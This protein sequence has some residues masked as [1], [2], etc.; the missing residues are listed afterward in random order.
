MAEEPEK[1]QPMLF[2]ESV[3]GEDDQSTI[4]TIAMVNHMSSAMT[5]A[6]SSA[7]SSSGGG[8]FSGGGSGGGFR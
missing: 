1:H 4:G 2:Q 8:G 7:G 6:S 3:Y 5:R